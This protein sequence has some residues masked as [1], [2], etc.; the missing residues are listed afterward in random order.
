MKKEKQKKEKKKEKKEKKKNK[1]TIDLSPFSG[2]VFC[3]RRY[4]SGEE[5]KRLRSPVDVR[6]LSVCDVL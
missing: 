4:L 5:R 2:G 6:S 1:K 3:F